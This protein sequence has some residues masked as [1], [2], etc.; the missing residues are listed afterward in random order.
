METKTG[1]LYGIGVGPGDPELMTLKAARV[2][3]SCDVIALPSP[4][5]E[6]CTA[7]AIASANLPELRGKPLLCVDMPMTKDLQARE[8]AYQTATAALAG[9]LAAG[10]D[11]GF[12]TLGDPTVY[13]TYLYLH[14]RVAALGYAAEIIPGVTSFCA[15]AARLGV[16]LCENREPL[17]ILPGTYG[18]R[19][20]LAYSG[21]RVV[22]KNDL[23]QTLAALREAG[24][25]AML[26][27]NCGMA[28]E[29]VYR[30]L[31]EIPEDGGYFSVLIVK[32][33]QEKNN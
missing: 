23:P 3:R 12:L 2:A 10:R 9:E 17:H 11:V 28:G 20:V 7:W 25:E 16:S 26:V 31:A 5:P 14:S 1:T 24:A 29:R 33:K 8:R 32:D 13:S 27:E 15:A 22:M 19:E 21:T 6:E 30:T 4:R 18:P